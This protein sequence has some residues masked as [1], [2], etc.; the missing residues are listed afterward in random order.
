MTIGIAGKMP[1]IS[2]YRHVA[3]PVLPKPNGKPMLNVARSAL[4]W[5]ISTLIAVTATPPSDAKAWVMPNH[6]SF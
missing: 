4:C 2:R 1:V 3:A 6:F 5:L